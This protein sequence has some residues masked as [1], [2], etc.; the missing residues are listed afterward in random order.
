[1]RRCADHPLARRDPRRDRRIVGGSRGAD[2]YLVIASCLIKVPPTPVRRPAA[3]STCSDR[4]PRPKVVL[5]SP[6]CLVVRRSGWPRMGPRG[7]EREIYVT[8]SRL[9]GDGP[10]NGR[11][12]FARRPFHN[13]SLSAAL[14]ALLKFNSFLSP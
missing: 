8:P 14:K 13:S 6:R 7:R 12:Q 2:A 4:P 5:A 9:N 1:S 10:P 11:C 3:L